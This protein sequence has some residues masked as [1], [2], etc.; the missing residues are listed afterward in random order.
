MRFYCDVRFFP[1]PYGFVEYVLVTP[2]EHKTFIFTRLVVD[3]LLIKGYF[4]A[5]R[6]SFG[7]RGAPAVL[8]LVIQWHET[9]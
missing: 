9:K 3:C 6:V 2:L 1:Q 4:F 5:S 7:A 8:R